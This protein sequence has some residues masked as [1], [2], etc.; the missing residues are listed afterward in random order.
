L[1][2]H[3]QA[4]WKV[5]VFLAI[6]FEPFKNVSSQFHLNDVTRVWD[7]VACQ[8]SQ[9]IVTNNPAFRR[10]VTQS[11]N[12]KNI[13]SY[14]FRWKERRILTW[15]DIIKVITRIILS[16]LRRP[17]QLHQN[18]LK[19]SGYCDQPH[20]KKS[21]IILSFQKYSLNIT[22]FKGKKYI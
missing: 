15:N 22:S 18:R 21:D 19:E 8:L 20:E 7:N 3:D 4:N 17:G 13:I 11:I 16:A 9:N 10:V 1:L 14:L 2:L 6:S 12:L 5:D